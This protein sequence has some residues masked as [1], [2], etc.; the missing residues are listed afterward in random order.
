M[1][2]IFLSE[3]VNKGRTAQVYKDLATERFV[4]KMFEGSLEDTEHYGT[5]Q[6]AENAAEDWVL[7]AQ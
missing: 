4:V 1:S 7:S 5:E 6:Q 3:Y 2:K